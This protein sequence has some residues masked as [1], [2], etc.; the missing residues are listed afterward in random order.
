MA[1]PSVERTTIPGLL[2]VHLDLHE[3]GRGWFEEIWHR[4]TMTALG[5]PDFGPVQAN[6]S[7]NT[8][9]GATRGIHAEPW[10]KYVTV[11]TGRAYGAWVDLREGATFG[12]VVTREL[13]PGVAVF[14][15]RGVGNS[16][17][18]LE[19]GTA[20]S[21]LINRHWQ[22]DERYPSVRLDDPAV[23]I[24]WPIPLAQ[25]RVSEKDLSNPPLAELEPIRERRALVLGA[26]GQVGRALAEAFPG[27]DAVSRRELD[28][29]DTEA[30]AAWPWHDYDVVLNAAAYTDV[31]GAEDP[32]GRAAAWAVNAAAPAVLSRLAT[33]H[34]LTLV[35]YSTDYVFD[36]RRAEHREDEAP[37]PLGVYG[38]SKAAGDLG[39]A[40][41]PRHYVVR[42]SWVVGDGSNFVRTMRRS[43]EQGAS[44]SVV[45]DQIGRLTFASEIARGTR[46]L[47]DSGAP[48]GTYNVTNAGEPWSWADVA[49]EVFELAGR[50]RSDVV[51]VSTEQYAATRPSAPR[52]PSSVLDLAKLRATGFE[53][54]DQRDALR[55]Y[56]ARP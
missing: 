18:T 40:V 32:E 34:R 5:L 14:V 4:A 54:E 1:R 24:A 38:Q 10:D 47:V 56:W 12:Q 53:P 43:A 35:H 11:A 8:S 41:T 52:P 36:G 6:L 21:Y 16:F 2:V 44:P 49:A 50:R 15:P 7:W 25:A 51:R 26:G 55:A 30:L 37:S 42:S 3:D 20:Y 17:Q 22:A 27:A 33:E 29:T 23:G 28:V 48:Y 13:A 31:D 9:R 39:V 19:D 45:G 46:H